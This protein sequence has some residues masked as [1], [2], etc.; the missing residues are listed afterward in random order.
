M[1]SIVTITNLFRDASGNLHFILVWAFILL[2]PTLLIS[3]WRK[4]EVFKTGGRLA[5]SILFMIIDI[6]AVILLL[7]FMETLGVIGFVVMFAYYYIRTW[8]N[9]QIYGLKMI[10]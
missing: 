2:V 4:R 1:N 10:D 6:N 5:I 3:L 7:F 8:I 9:N